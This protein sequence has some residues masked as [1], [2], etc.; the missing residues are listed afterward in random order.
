MNHP[1][2]LMAWFAEHAPGDVQTYEMVC[3]V[4]GAKGAG[5]TLD[6]NGPPSE[7]RYCPHCREEWEVDPN[8]G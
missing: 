7:I 1:R 5:V 6:G 4:C 3:A 2:D 8:P